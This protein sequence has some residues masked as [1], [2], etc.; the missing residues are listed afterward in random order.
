MRMDTIKFLTEDELALLL[1]I[2]N[3][4]EPMTFPKMEIGVK[5]LPWLR[6]KLLVEKL[7]RQ[8]DKLKPEGLEILKTLVSKITRHPIHEAEENER[9]L[10]NPVG[11]LNFQ[12]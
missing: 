5:E 2:V 3:V 10:R 11:Q 6:Q 7:A 12:F 9:T 8:H 1:Y 4:V